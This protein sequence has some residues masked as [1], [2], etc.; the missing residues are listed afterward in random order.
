M[1]LCTE[2]KNNFRTALT[3]HSVACWCGTVWSGTW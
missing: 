2:I 1:S 3:I